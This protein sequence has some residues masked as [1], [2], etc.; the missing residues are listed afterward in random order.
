M[1]IETRASLFATG[2]NIVV[3]GDMVRRTLLASMDGEREGQS[4]ASSS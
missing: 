2:N 1:R 3:V 4:C